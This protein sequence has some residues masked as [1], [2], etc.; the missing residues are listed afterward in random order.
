MTEK[1]TPPL[2]DPLPRPS[3]GEGEKMSRAASKEQKASKQ[4]IMQW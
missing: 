2:P 1:G 3:G 4:Q